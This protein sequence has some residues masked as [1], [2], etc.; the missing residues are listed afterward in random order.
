MNVPIFC[1]QAAFGAAAVCTA[2]ISPAAM[3]PPNILFIFADDLSYEAVG[4]LN[5]QDIDTPNLD[6]LARRGT[7][8]SCAYNMGSYHGAVCIASRT[9]LNTGRSLWNAHGLDTAPQ[10]AA[11]AAQGRLWPQRMQQAGYRTYMTGKWH[12]KIAADTVFDVVADER[13]GMPE[14]TEEGY[15]RPLSEA[16]YET[17]WKPWDTKYGGFWEGGRHWSEIVGDHTVDFLQQASK[18][19]RPF[20]IY[21]AFNSP[22]DPHQAPKEYID[23]YPLNRIQLPENYLPKY[24]HQDDI[25]CGK[26]LRDERLA[27]FPRTEYAA[28]VQRQ[29]YFAQITHMDTQIGRILDALQESG[30]ADHTLVIFTS[31]HGLAKG[32]HGFMGKQ[33]MYEHSMRVPILLSGPGIPAGKTVAKPVYLQDIMPTTL[34]LAGADIP[35]SID[36]K[37]LLPLI[38]EENLYADKM[39]YGAYRGLQRMILREGWKLIF[40]PTLGI[41]RLYHLESDPHEIRDL[42]QDPDCS[43][44]LKALRSEL[45]D[46]SRTVN[47]P[48]DY[49]NP[50]ESW[51]T[52][53]EL[54]TRM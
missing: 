5:M 37:S 46:L 31:D 41:E 20:F 45:R 24:P 27:P 15:N 52:Y 13:G 25:G 12:I 19:D 10:M 38:R 8:F 48:L 44:R 2:P 7:L 22:H 6:R 18:E 39:I 4:A 14:Q 32:R 17:G 23:R 3:N 16:D 11:E 54:K 36:F 30:L 50:E 1:K 9:M 33:N 29:E 34:Q 40:Y 43:D 49:E 35:D 51:T 28:K 53:F 42:A 21:A 26:A 47:D